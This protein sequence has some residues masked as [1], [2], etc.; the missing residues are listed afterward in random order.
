MS[1]GATSK[2]H[3]VKSVSS[4]DMAQG[5]LKKRKSTIA[6]PSKNETKSL[7]S[8]RNKNNLVRA[9]T[10]TQMAMAGFSKPMRL[11][12]TS[13]V[14][15]P[16]KAEAHRTPTIGSLNPAIKLLTQQKQYVGIGGSKSPSGA[17]AT[18]NVFKQAKSGPNSRSN[19]GGLKVYKKQTT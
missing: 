5:A 18:H 4:N 10:M 17:A 8:V 16:G 13:P 3:Q 19:S 9:G 1:N 2:H 14:H 7:N 15:G 12:P 6:A 11:Q